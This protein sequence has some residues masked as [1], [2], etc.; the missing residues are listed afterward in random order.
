MNSGKL[1]EHNLENGVLSVIKNTSE[2]LLQGAGIGSDYSRLK[3]TIS[4]DGASSEPAIAWAKAYN[5]FLCSGGKCTCARITMLLSPS[6]KES[7][8]KS[9]MSIFSELS[10]QQGIQIVGGHSEIC[11][12]YQKDTFLVTLIGEALEWSP[13]K[14]TADCCIFMTGY[15]GLLG[16]NLLLK[17]NS[18]KINSYFGNHFSSGE[19]FGTEKYICPNLLAF[20]ESS[21][22]M[23]AHD[24]SSDGVYGA[25]W[26]LGKKLGKG[27]EVYNWLIPIRQETIEICECLDLN[28][29][30]IDGTGAMLF[31]CN[32]KAPIL[33]HLISQ[34]IETK[35][36]GKLTAEKERIV[37]FTEE[38]YRTLSP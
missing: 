24:I 36:I 19:V 34:G 11:E 28:P 10:D 17:E 13:Q 25:L 20:D 12:A 8:I 32:K 33:Q 30:T 7:Q 15:A 31:V 1:R 26:Q 16:T 2:E 27:I 29:Y 5:N 4:S 21:S 18:E 23:Y 14:A 3:N 9:Y 38:E 6:V 35:C 37:Y 22:I